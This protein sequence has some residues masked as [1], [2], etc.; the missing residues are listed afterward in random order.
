[1]VMKNGQHLKIKPEVNLSFVSMI[2]FTCQLKSPKKLKDQEKRE[3]P[4]ERRMSLREELGTRKKEV[5]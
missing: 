4:E 3:E 1:M 2:L 5:H